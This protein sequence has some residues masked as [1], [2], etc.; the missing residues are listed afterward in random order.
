METLK[1]GDL[2]SLLK[3]PGTPRNANINGIISDASVLTCGCLV[4]ESF[5]LSTLT[6]NSIDGASTCPN[7][8][9]AQVSLLTPITPLRELY[10]IIQQ[11]NSQLTRTRRRS[12]RNSHESIRHGSTGKRGSETA[13]G[14]SNSSSSESMDLL[15]LFFKY[16][17]EENTNPEFKDVNFPPKDTQPID[18]KLP[19]QT[20]TSGSISPHNNTITAALKSKVPTISSS[21][22][23]TPTQ[24]HNSLARRLSNPSLDEV[25]T[26]L[27]LD[28]SFLANLNEEKEFNFS[29]CFPFYRKLTTFPTQQLK[30]NFSSITSNPFK[31]GSN[32]MIKKSTRYIASSIH[33]FNE[34]TAEVT[35][36]V[37]LSEKRWEVYEYYVGSDTGADYKPVL[38]C[39]GKLNGEY[40][41]AF[42][43]LSSSSS[44]PGE[45][46]IKNDFGNSS[47]NQTN[48][49]YANNEDIKKKLGSW[50]HLHCKISANFLIIAGTKGMMRVFNLNSKLGEVGKPIYTYVTNFPIRCVSIS[51]N[52]AL[53]ACSITARERLSG[54]EQPFII[55]HKLNLAIKNS[56]KIIESVEP[57]TITIPYRDPIK[58]INFN[59]SSTHILCCTVWESRYLIIKLRGENSDNYR[60]PRLIWTDVRFLRQRRKKSDLTYMNDY[61]SADENDYDDEEELM[62]DNEGITDLQFGNSNSNTIILTLCSLKNKP[63]VVIRLDGPLIDS[64][65]KSVTSTTINPASNTPNTNNARTSNDLSDTFSQA[66]SLNSSINSRNDEKLHEFNNIK[67]ADILLRIPEVGS[68]IHRL[69]LSP[70]GDGLV[71][72]DKNGHLY[73]VSLPNFQF[74]S[75]TNNKKIV[76]L[77]GEVANAERYTESAS[78]KFSSDGGK[79]F[80]VDRKGVF[81]VF[82][83]TKGVPGEDVDVVK[84][85]ILNI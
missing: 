68:S 26:R 25:S 67:N 77:L 78:V 35:R 59:F 9:K 38:L 23:T 60:K 6:S 12:N 15:G 54:K 61:D 41:K 70:R 20:V 48:N 36:F 19:A 30:F 66:L 11:L 32:S 49:I 71:F 64:K 34:S 42:G 84:C 18:I 37:L 82:D 55:L 21:T 14:V 28:E 13:L 3:F 50:E 17:K 81:S 1:L 45:I 63:P 44:N 33:T 27:S 75:S 5:F 72:L 39:C 53:L 56:N 79:V 73:L 62:M 47:S 57:I 10:T 65:H 52:E 43:N 40:G 22:S 74:N 29:K 24:K 46:I 2:E 7:C 58:L 76:L 16:A 80:V 4:S 51:P 83:F 31:A 69:A 8:Q 85:K